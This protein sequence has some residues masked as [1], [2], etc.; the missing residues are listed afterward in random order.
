[1]AKSVEMEGKGSRWGEGKMRGEEERMQEQNT[2][3]FVRKKDAGSRWEGSQCCDLPG[4]MCRYT[5][6]SGWL[7]KVR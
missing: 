1:M 2:G 6:C 3:G 7:M 5:V 4:G